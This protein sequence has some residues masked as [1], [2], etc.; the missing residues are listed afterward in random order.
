MDITFY[1]KIC[2]FNISGQTYSLHSLLFAKPRSCY[3]SE[4]CVNAGTGDG[5][6]FGRCG[7]TGVSVDFFITLLYALY[8]WCRNNFLIIAYT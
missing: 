7:L 2:G 6:H 3:A 8:E 5:S 4:K 1:V